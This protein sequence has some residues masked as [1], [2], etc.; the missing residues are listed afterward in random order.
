MILEGELE[1]GMR[2]IA[3]YAEAVI[4][5]TVG[6]L[7]FQAQVLSFEHTLPYSRRSRFGSEPGFIV[8]GGPHVRAEFYLMPISKPVA[9]NTVE[10]VAE[11][12]GTDV[13]FESHRKAIADERKKLAALKLANAALD[14]R[15]KTECARNAEQATL[16]RSLTTECEKMRADLANYCKNPPPEAGRFALLE[17]E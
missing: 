1:P 8:G 5:V 2:E 17:T 10:E 11:K 14:E 6:H 4:P 3:P 16:L 7:S 9:C 12:F 13:S 15:L